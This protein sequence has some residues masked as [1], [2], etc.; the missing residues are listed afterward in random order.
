MRVVD[1]LKVGTRFSGRRAPPHK[2]GVPG[3]SD[4]VTRE[5]YSH[6][7]SSAGFWSGGWRHRLPGILHMPTLSPPALTR[8]RSNRTR[9]FSAKRSGN[10]SYRMTLL[11]PLVILTPQ[12]IAFLQTTYDAATDL[13]GWDCPHPSVRWGA[14]AFRA[15][16]HCFNEG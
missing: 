4:A 14:P 3:V 7:L 1:I 12:L 13:G 16:F 15:K 6:E 5:A 2:G 8:Q 11:E 9:R 10:L